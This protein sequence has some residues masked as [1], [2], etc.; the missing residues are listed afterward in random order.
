[1]YVYHSKQNLLL[2]SL[3]VLLIGSVS[4]KPLPQRLA[5]P[6]GLPCSRDQLT[7]YTGKI[8]RYTRKSSQIFLQVRTDEATTERFQ[9]S[10]SKGKGYLDLYLLNGAAITKTE[11]EKIERKLTKKTNDVRV[12]VWECRNSAHR[13]IDWRVTQ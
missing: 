5:P 6:S 8:L 9:I 10:I 4:S 1:M 3:L 11:L 2:V 12:T 7:S 13:I